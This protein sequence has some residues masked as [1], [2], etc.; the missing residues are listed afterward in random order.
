[1]NHAC[2]DLDI[3]CPYDINTIGDAGTYRNRTQKH[4]QGSDF[5][6]A[7]ILPSRLIADED[8]EKYHDY[9]VKGQEVHVSGEILLRPPVAG[10]DGRRW[11]EEYIPPPRSKQHQKRQRTVL[12]DGVLHVL[13][14]LSDLTILNIIS[15]GEG[16]IIAMAIL[17]PEVR[18][19]AYAERKVSD[20]ERA[21]LESFA[22]A[23][24]YVILIAPHSFPLHA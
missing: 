20:T 16:A 9:V 11:V 12:F 15:L 8:E 6:P 24:Q 18:S 5:G 1:M 22:L 17:S 3:P 10:T 23:L 21:L 14:Q 19:A 2:T 13:R 7:V 4:V